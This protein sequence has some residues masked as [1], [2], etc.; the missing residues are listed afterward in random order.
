MG[1][2]GLIIVSAGIALLAGC[3]STTVGQPESTPLAHEMARPDR[4][5][6]YD[7]VGT[8]DD[9]PPDSAIARYY[10]ERTTPQTEVEID[11]GRRL[12]RLVA[13]NLVTELNSAGIPAQHAASVPETRIGDGII[14]GEFITI[15]EGSRTKRVLI[16]FGAGA[17]ELKTLAEAYLVTDAGLRPVGSMQVD[18]AG[19]KLPGMLVPVGVGASAVVAGSANVMQERGPEA[20]RAAAQRT[21]KELAKLIIDAY[22]Q[23][24]WL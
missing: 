1:R 6:V 24:G 20:I 14:R 10:E 4:V 18:A 23:R 19:G 12:G 3:A 2:V 21:A 16:G 7:F 17:G 5:V 8:H 13:Q 22:S 15:K 11:L 9:L